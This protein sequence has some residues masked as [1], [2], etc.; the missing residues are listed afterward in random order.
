MGLVTQITQPNNVVAA[1]FTDGQLRTKRATLPALTVFRLLPQTIPNATWTEIQYQVSSLVSQYGGSEFGSPAFP[2]TEFRL[3]G[4]FG[5]VTANVEWESNAT[6]IRGIRILSNGLVQF[7]DVRGAVATTD[8]LLSSTISAPI[9]HASDSMDTDVSVE[10]YQS[11][12]G[13]LGVVNTSLRISGYE[14]IHASS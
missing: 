13:D 3:P 6:G 9:V 14:Q 2:A 12:T 7:S 8:P 11:S 4:I 10:V 5:M 1:Q